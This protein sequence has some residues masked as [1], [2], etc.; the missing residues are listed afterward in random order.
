MAKKDYYKILG[1]DKKASAD[2]IKK[3][4][5][6]LSLKWHPDK[7][8]SKSD[9]EKKTAEEKFKD[10]AEAYS[11][12]SDENKRKQYDMF[13]TVD[14]ASF[15]SGSFDPFD[16]FRK[17]GGFNDFDPFE[18]F[19]Q[20]KRV[21]RGGSIQF[22][23]KLTLEELYN[24]A[25]HTI[26]YKRYKPCK[27]CKGKGTKNGKTQTCPYCNGSGVI[28]QMYQNGYMTSMQQTPCHHCHGEGTIITDPCPKCGGTGLELVEETFSFNVPIGCCDNVYTVVEGAGHYPTRGEGI[29]GDLKLVFNVLPHE[30]YSIDDKDY[31][32][33]LVT[34]VEVP[35]LDCIT[36]CEREIKDLNGET[37]KLNIKPCTKHGDKIVLENKGL[38]YKPYKRGSITVVVKQKI[39]S[40]IN[41]DE[42]KI[43][44]E[45]KKSDNFK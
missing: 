16:I 1:V 34:S 33:N 29:N 13:G 14:G 2:D 38:R 7:W 41:I 6:K 43:I 35:V 22:N 5:R 40:K 27:E 12:L 45:L 4:Y 3:N 18:S 39:P 17:M 44:N 24:N 37:I 32:F 30:T 21:N 8:A 10:I 11:V 28:T 25:K 15:S 20:Q 19:T 42:E 31:P 9:K 36:G 23:V 26:K